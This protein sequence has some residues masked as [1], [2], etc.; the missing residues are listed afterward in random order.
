MP[1]LRSLTLLD[2]RECSLMEAQRASS[3]FPRHGNPRS[4]IVHYH[5]VG[6]PNLLLELPLDWHRAPESVVVAW[7]RDALKR[8]DSA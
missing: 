6:E 3:D 7:V 8:F 1:F 2:G 5:C 4:A